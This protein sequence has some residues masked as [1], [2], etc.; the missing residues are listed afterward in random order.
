[1]RRFAALYAALDQTTKTNAK[2]DAMVEYFADVPAQDA[3]WALYFLVGERPKRLVGAPVL[4]LWALQVTGVPPWL[5]EEAY[6]AVGDLARGNR[7]AGELV[8]AP[9]SA[10]AGPWMRRFAEPVTAFASGW[11]RV[12]GQRRRRG[13]DRGFVISDHADWPDLLRTIAATGARRVV[14][15]HGYTEALARFLREERGLDAEALRILDEGEG[16]DG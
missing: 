4:R 12:R 1:M 6:A 9:P 3:A 13:Y 15:A 10:L 16:D 7:L 14:C 5:A 2:I 11:M 8:L